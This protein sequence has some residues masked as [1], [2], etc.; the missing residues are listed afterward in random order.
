VIYREPGFPP[1]SKLSLFLGGGGGGRG[2][3]GDSDD[4]KKVWPSINHSKLSAPWVSTGGNSVVATHLI[5]QSW[6]L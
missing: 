2:G 4:R 1:V 5:K 6:N 3:D